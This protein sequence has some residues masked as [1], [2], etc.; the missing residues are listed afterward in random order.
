MRSETVWS[1]VTVVVATYQSKPSGPLGATARV[2]TPMAS[3]RT[4]RSFRGGN[5]HETGW[6]MGTGGDP[7]G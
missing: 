7:S 6:P 3:Y 5:D 4:I 2:A 1:E